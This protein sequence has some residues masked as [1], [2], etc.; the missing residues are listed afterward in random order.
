M[1]VRFGS[2]TD[3]GRARERN[4]DS[5]LVR[6]P[7]FV[8]ADGMGGHRGG[9]VASAMATE[10]LG[11]ADLRGDGALRTLVD[12]IKEANRIVL[13]RGQADRELRGMG[14]TVTA[15]L[16]DGEK[17]HVAHVGDSRAYLMRSGAFQQ[18]TEDHTLVQRMVR[19][20]KLTPEQAVHHP[21]RSI[22]TRALGVEEELPVDELTLTVQD[23]DRLL[24]ATDGLTAMV[25]DVDIKAILE[26]EADPQT[27]CDRL[28][29]AANRGGGDDNI[30]VVVLDFVV[31][32][33]PGAARTDEDT[34]MAGAGGRSTQETPASAT[35]MP[36]GAAPTLAIAAAPAGAAVGT[37]T[38]ER[39]TGF[40]RASSFSSEPRARK[41][42]G[43]RWGRVVL[44]IAVL[45]AVVAAALVGTKLYVDRQWY[46]GESQGKVAVYNGIP[47]VVF[48]YKL[49]HVD[50]LSNLS[51]VSAERLQQWTSLKDGITATSKTD[52]ERV[53]TQIG[54]DL[55]T[56]T[57]A[58]G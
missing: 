7:L 3:V 26:A 29:E 11:E 22:I 48:G 12:Q 4:E 50:Q 8:V 5:M 43:I 44:W 58:G 49:S 23:G 42:R 27:A 17:A 46:V 41:G 10:K 39:P 24:L 56:K 36:N 34:I 54:L 18:L 51:A 38:A 20:G 47:T 19:E 1:R 55:R 53:V 45:G 32:G 33:A 40:E 30:T 57:G 16:L 25:D 13:E 15:V 31:E 2:Q 37:Q 35:G 21:Q 14:T 52:A 9:N 6:A 28:V